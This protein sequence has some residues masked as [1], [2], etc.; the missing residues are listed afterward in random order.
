M[1]RM[2]FKGID[3]YRGEGVGAMDGGFLGTYAGAY[4]TTIPSPRK[5]LGWRVM[6]SD[7]NTRHDSY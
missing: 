5:V 6:V 2:P 1:Q 3:V 7:A 4:N